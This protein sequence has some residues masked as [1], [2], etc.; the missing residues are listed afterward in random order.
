M[1]RTKKITKNILWLSNQLPKEQYSSRSA[2][3]LEGKEIIESGQKEI[4][5]QPVVPDKKY[6]QYIPLYK[7]VCHFRR[8]KRAYDSN[9][10]E[11]MINYLSQYLTK[12][13][14]NE[15]INRLKPAF[16]VK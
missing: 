6:I 9:G 2:V 16:G 1:K 11:G 14:K 8:L 3:I 13:D 15:L 7:D 4:E 10:F 5:K 12:G